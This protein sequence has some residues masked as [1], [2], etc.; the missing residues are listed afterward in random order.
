MADDLLNVNNEGGDD[1]SKASEGG[2]GG[3][4]QVTLTADNWKDFIPEELK[5]RAEWDRVNSI[6]DVLSNYIQQGQTISKSVRIPDSSSTQE[7]INAFY[8]KL[9]KPVDKAGYTF[10][11]T[12]SK[13]EYLYDKDSFDF[14]VFQELADTA[15]LSLNQY[16]ALASKYIDIQNENAIRAQ[17]EFN[18]QASR[19]LRDAETLLREK[20]GNQ[21]NNN[22][23]AIS[24]RIEK[25]YPKETLEKMAQAGLFRDPAF[26]ERQLAL[27]KMQTGDTL[28]IDG[29][30]VTDVPQTLEALTQQRDE[31]MQQDYAKNRAQVKELN[32]KI[33]QLK[34]AQRG[35][36]SRSVL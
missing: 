29:N 31:L 13:E 19:E 16:Q 9:G 11:Y 15:N 4:T 36:V 14:T 33:V 35:Q 5:D 28:V 27:T 32:Q 8:Q 1:G 12:K 25:S 18:A 24:S 2:D 17:E 20:W 3:Q 10:D 22:I 34:A 26:L 21:Y 30:I 6:S 7:Q 23:N